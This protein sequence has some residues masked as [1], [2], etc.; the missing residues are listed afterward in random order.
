MKLNLY[1]NRF[2]DY[3]L[4]LKSLLICL[5]F[6]VPSI[7][8]S[9]VTE[10]PSI[11]TTE[12]FKN[13]DSTN[14]LSN[15]GTT[16]SLIYFSSFKTFFEGDNEIVWKSLNIKYRAPD[17]RD[18]KLKL[19]YSDFFQLLSANNEYAFSQAK[20]I[21]TTILLPFRVKENSSLEGGTTTSISAQLL[22]NEQELVKEAISFLHYKRKSSWDFSAE[23]SNPLWLKNE[24]EKKVYVR[25]SNKSNY[26]Q[27]FNVKL[28]A[29]STQSS[30]EKIFKIKKRA[31]TALAFKIKNPSTNSFDENR[32]TI[33]VVN[34]GET[35][36]Q[37][38]YTHNP[39]SNYE[40][41]TYFTETP[42]NLE[43][44][45]FNFGSGASPTY[46]LRSWGDIHFS[47]NERLQYSFNF[48]NILFDSPNV[49]LWRYSRLS[50]IADFPGLTVNAGD[51]TLG[52]FY[53]EWGRGLSAT[54]VFQESNNEVSLG[55]VNNLFFDRTTYNASGKLRF[56]N[57]V[58]RPSFSRSTDASNLVQKI[59]GNIFSDFRIKKHLISAGLSFSQRQHLYDT[60]SFNTPSQF[61][62]PGRTLNGYAYSLRYG[63]S[64]KLWRIRLKTRTKSKYH[65]GAF[66]GTQNQR[67]QVTRT[68][69]RKSRVSGRVSRRKFEPS[70]TFRGV[71]SNL[72]YYDLTRA[73]LLYRTEILKTNLSFGTNFL[74][75]EIS[76]NLNQLDGTPLDLNIYTSPR[77]YTRLSG[78]ISS[79][80]ISAQAQVGPVYLNQT[81]PINFSNNAYQIGVNITDNISNISLRF[82]DGLIIPS[83]TGLNSYTLNNS[84]SFFLA[85]RY[86]KTLLDQMLDLNFNLNYSNYIEAQST[87]VSAFLQSD[88]KL[89]HGIEL[90]AYLNFSTVNYQNRETQTQSLFTN[91]GFALRKK[92][93]VNQPQLKYFDLSF[94]T[95]FD[96]NGNNQ[97]DSTE[98]N[99]QN[100]LVE[101]ENVI[102]DNQS[103]EKRLLSN[104][105]GKVNFKDLPEGNYTA[106]FTPVGKSEINLGEKAIS[107]M[108]NSDKTEDIPLSEEYSLKGRVIFQKAKFSSVQSLDFSKIK[109]IING[110]RG[111]EIKTWASDDG[112]FNFNL[113]KTPGI[114]KLSIDTSLLPDN[115]LVEKQSYYFEMN[116]LKSYSINFKLFEKER[117]LNITE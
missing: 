83:V 49:D 44:G 74:Y 116:G 112:R 89:N 85:Y 33:E 3:L 23:L 97:L 40:N 35:K 87:L 81:T 96:E 86:R 45:A 22:I 10:G 18:F 102:D 101:L 109:L 48:F 54:K 55:A 8:Y 31:D 61:Y 30:E 34:S 113:N 12:F 57:V 29:R 70:E 67:L 111:K 69:S 115:I 9:Q 80:R 51:Q 58:L 79:Y 11:D 28:K 25:V 15:P 50:I 71:L 95:F 63:F 68:I 60:N 42:A 78:K 13:L 4:N 56:G 59:E 6:I 75:S 117:K 7:I 88:L 16:D 76:N 32:I 93:D 99:I 107:F 92:F 72:N 105:S 19:F 90:S 5:I 47:S 26:T 20:E 36:R 108:L 110:P 1:L 46:S 104:E 82:N 52:N 27:T 65:A 38:L 77:I 37:I 43:V 84:Q 14:N 91:A 64:N 98:L 94:N 73:M 53:P 114:Y 39:G 100:V 21:D 17:T 2:F 41:T 66:T 106:H 24:A 62:L 103:V